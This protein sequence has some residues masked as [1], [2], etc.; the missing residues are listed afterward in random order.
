MKKNK[1]VIDLDTI[2]KRFKFIRDNMGLSLRELAALTGLT[3]PAIHQ[4]EIEKKI[5]G[6]QFDNVIRYSDVTGVNIHWLLTGQGP[7]YVSKAI[8]LNDLRQQM[9]YEKIELQIKTEL[10]NQ[11]IKLT[12]KAVERL[13]DTVYERTLMN[14]PPTKKELSQLIQLIA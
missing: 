3:A 1:Q 2:T 11:K 10:N 7:M 14:D 4:W 6:S 8:K 5:G 13:I 12:K 9:L